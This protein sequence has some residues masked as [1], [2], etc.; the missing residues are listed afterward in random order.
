MQRRT[1]PGHTDDNGQDV[2]YFFLKENQFAIS[3]DI[4]DINNIIKQL[5]ILY[6]KVRCIVFVYNSG[7]K[8]DKLKADKTQLFTLSATVI[9]PFFSKKFPGI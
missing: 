8:C 5:N 4:P 9:T 3:I 2:T 7:F 6:A 1:A